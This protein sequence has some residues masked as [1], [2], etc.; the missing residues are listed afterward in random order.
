MDVDHDSPC[1]IRVQGTGY[2][3]QKNC[4]KKLHK[5]NCHLLK[6]KAVDVSGNKIEVVDLSGT[7]VEVKVK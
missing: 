5:G 6:V 4:T 3:V 2:R 1:F 7:K